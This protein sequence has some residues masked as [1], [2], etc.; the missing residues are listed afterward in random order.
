MAIEQPADTV[1]GNDVWIGR[2]ATI[3]P[4]ISI[5]DG[6]IIG[7][8]SVVTRNVEPYAIVAGHPAGSVRP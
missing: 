4:G 3:M 1:V 7:A 2:E 6:A 5:G 8:H